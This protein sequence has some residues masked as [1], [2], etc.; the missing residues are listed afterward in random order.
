MRNVHGFCLGP[1]HLRAPLF[2]DDLFDRVHET[3]LAQTGFPN[4]RHHL[5]HPFLS[6]L[7]AISE[8]AYF[9]ITTGQRS[10]RDWRWR[11]NPTSTGRALLR[12]HKLFGRIHDSIKDQSSPD[13]GVGPAQILLK[14][15]RETVGS[16]S[17]PQQLFTRVGERLSLNGFERKPDAP[18][19][20]QR[21]GWVGL[22]D[23]VAAVADPIEEAGYQAR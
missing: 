10:E 19:S 15:R 6:L 22:Q 2:R 20:K 5:T 23:E 13:V 17:S 9:G 4:D 18:A 1:R 12:S 16:D 3:R 21:G 8:Q 11:M 14:P 7:P